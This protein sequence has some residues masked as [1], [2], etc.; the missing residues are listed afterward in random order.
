MNDAI[1][2]DMNDDIILSFKRRIELAE[3][4]TALSADDNAL[5]RH[6][7]LG[8]TRLIKHGK[9]LGTILRFLAGIESDIALGHQELNRLAG[10]DR[11]R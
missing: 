1:L 3:A 7:H 5:R 4:H 10:I 2:P 9:D 8:A 6:A 11:G